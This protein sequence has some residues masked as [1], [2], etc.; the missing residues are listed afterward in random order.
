MKGSDYQWFHQKDMGSGIQSIWGNGVVS[1]TVT[2]EWISLLYAFICEEETFML[3][4]FIDF[5]ETKMTQNKWT[6]LPLLDQV[7]S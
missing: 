5:M 4:L 6:H 2:N 3:F 7:I 1:P